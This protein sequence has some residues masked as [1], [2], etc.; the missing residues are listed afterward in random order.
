MNLRRYE[1]CLFVRNSVT[2]AQNQLTR[3]AKYVTICQFGA[4]SVLSYA[5]ATLLDVRLERMCK[6]CS[7]PALI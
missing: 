5:V 2:V 1:W 3:L 7:M 6:Q 4:D